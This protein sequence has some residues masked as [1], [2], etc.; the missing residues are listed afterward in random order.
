VPKDKI[1]TIGMGEKQPL[2][3]C[4]QKN[5]KELIACLQ[6]NRRVE[7]EVKGETKK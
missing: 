3:Q 7:V 4:D 6:P 1:E 2:V 5:L